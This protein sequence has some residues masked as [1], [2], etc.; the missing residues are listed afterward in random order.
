MY[1][2][3]VDIVTL[4]HPYKDGS[5]QKKLEVENHFNSQGMTLKKL[6]P[7][8]ESYNESLEHFDHKI[9]LTVEFVEVDQ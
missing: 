2:D 3:E 7:L 1:L 9:K 8:L 5:K 4:N 6:L